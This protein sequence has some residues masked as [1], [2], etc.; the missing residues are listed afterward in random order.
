MFD[1]CCSCSCTETWLSLI[2]DQADVVRT[3]AALKFLGDSWRNVHSLIVTGYLLPFTLVCHTGESKVLSAL[4]DIT[5]RVFNIRVDVVC[6]VV[7]VVDWED[8]F[9]YD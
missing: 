9:T 1:L 5:V 3:P 6:T 7:N 8:V 4:L 2:T